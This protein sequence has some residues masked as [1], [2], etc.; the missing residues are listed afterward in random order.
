MA[1]REQK[2]GGP[3]SGPSREDGASI[4]Q[5]TILQG[6]EPFEMKQIKG[7]FCL[8]AALVIGG[9][10]ATTASALSTDNPQWEVESALLGA[11]VGQEIMAIKN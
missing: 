6:K 7:G 5:K 9:L 4:L 8:M 10:S 1:R 3:P 11:G 2:R